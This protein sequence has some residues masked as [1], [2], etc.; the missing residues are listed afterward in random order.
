M[1][2]LSGFE[3]LAGRVERVMAGDAIW[4]RWLTHKLVLLY[5]ADF[6]KDRQQTDYRS[7][8]KPI[9]KARFRF[10]H[11]VPVE[12]EE[13]GNPEQPASDRISILVTK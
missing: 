7:H 8:T 4:M 2:T 10:G 12:M 13:A 3:G 5:R 9:A 6:G 11:V 1:L